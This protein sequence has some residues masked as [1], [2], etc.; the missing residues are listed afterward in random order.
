[1]VVTPTSEDWIG[2]S[3][4]CHAISSQSHLTAL[5]PHGICI[6]ESFDGV[7]SFS[8]ITTPSRAAFDVLAAVSQLQCVGYQKAR[9]DLS[10]DRSVGLGARQNAWRDG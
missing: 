8:L 2:N 3:L 1:M 5:G 10:E 6:A 9:L 7:T 4:R